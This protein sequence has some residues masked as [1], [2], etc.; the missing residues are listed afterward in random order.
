MVNFLVYTECLAR[1]SG[2]TSLQTIRILVC[3]LMITENIEKDIN[4]IEKSFTNKFRNTWKSL[5]CKGE[6]CFQ[7]LPQFQ[8]RCLPPYGQLPLTTIDVFEGES[9]ESPS[10]VPQQVENC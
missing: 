4:D 2:L 6:L 3:H 9:S 5:K 10:L 7:S 1:I 8:R